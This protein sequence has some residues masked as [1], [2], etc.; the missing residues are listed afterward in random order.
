MQMFSDAKQLQPGK[1]LLDH[2][3]ACLDSPE[4]FVVHLAARL[5]KARSP[6]S[7]LTEH[8]KF[9]LRRTALNSLA[10]RI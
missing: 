7:R 1:V 4:V 6:R 9:M 3:P 5:A 10:R 2:F 8:H